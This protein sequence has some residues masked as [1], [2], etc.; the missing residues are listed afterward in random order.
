MGGASLDLICAPLIRIHVELPSKGREVSLRMTLDVVA[1][2]TVKSIM[3]EIKEKQAFLPDNMHLAL[4]D[5]ELVEYRT[6]A[7]YRLTGDAVLR[8]IDGS[9]KIFVKTVKGI[10]LTLTLDVKPSDTI[11]GVKPK[12][13]D[14]E[15]FL[16]DNQR[17]IFAGRQLEDV[18][19]LSDYNIQR[20]STLHLVLCLSDRP[21][22]ATFWICAVLALLMACAVSVAMY[23]FFRR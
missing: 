3:A 1:S 20:E 17:L 7:D 8:L 4:D 12:I 5:V 13:Q 2:A 21:E 11:K 18:R 16:P 19:T 14:K 9:Y 23:Y 22:P 10:E 15:G 6:L